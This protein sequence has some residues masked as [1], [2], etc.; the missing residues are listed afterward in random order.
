VT[1][2]EKRAL[3]AERMQT[4]GIAYPPR[5]CEQL[6]AYQ[7]LLETWNTRI[8]LTGDASFDALLDNH[9]MDSLAPLTVQ[10]LLTFDGAVIDVGTGAGL[11]GIPLAIVRPDLRITLLDS[12]QKRIKFLRVVITELGLVNVTAIHIRAE[13]AARD[14]RFR[15]RF[16][17]ALARAVATLPVLMELLLP[18]VA[19]GGK[20]ICYKGPSVADELAAGSR[21]AKLL[22]GD[23]LCRISIAAPHLPQ[24]RHCLV[25]SEKQARTSGKYPRKAGVPSKNPLANAD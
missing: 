5:A 1:A 13:D 17:V 19:V 9:L 10:G 18:F 4:L 15:E 8:N 7:Q 22:G 16:D 3:L 2:E 14:A 21:A 25:V 23:P 6:L 11:P 24:Q 12:L 20:S